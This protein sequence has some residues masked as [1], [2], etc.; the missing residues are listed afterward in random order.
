MHHCHA[1]IPHLVAGKHGL[2]GQ[3][4]LQGRRLLCGL[5]KAGMDTV[6]AFHRGGIYVI[7]VTTATARGVGPGQ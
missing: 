3:G 4:L 7:R 2:L 1:A 6:G 5:F